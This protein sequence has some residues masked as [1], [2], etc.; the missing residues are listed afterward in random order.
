[1][2]KERMLLIVDNAIDYLDRLGNSKYNIDAAY[3]A[4]DLRDVATEIE[5]MTA[6]IDAAVAYLCQ[7]V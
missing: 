7:E 1:M 2:D 4:R 6:K 5:T 3:I